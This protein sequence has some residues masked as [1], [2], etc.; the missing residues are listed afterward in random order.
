M[1][2]I[3]YQTVGTWLVCSHTT[4]FQSVHTASLVTGL[5]FF[6]VSLLVLLE[7]LMKEKIQTDRSLPFPSP[8]QAISLACRS[9]YSSSK[10]YPML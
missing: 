3:F 4:V 9:Y 1:F 8:F 6:L 7:I 2:L 10:I 5:I